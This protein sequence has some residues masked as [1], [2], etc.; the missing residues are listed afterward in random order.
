[1]HLMQQICFFKLING[2]HKDKKERNNLLN[3]INHA[4][5]AYKEQLR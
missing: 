2:E 3:G 1:M 5:E 4:T